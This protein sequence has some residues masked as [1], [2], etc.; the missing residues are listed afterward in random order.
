MREVGG[1]LTTYCDCAMLEVLVVQVVP[2][3]T[4]N[5]IQ[6]LSLF[7]RECDMFHLIDMLLIFQL[8]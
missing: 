5:T 6:S 2:V 7:K 1:V 8:L 4:M 3:Y